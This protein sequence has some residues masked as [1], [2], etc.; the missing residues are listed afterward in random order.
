MKSIVYVDHVHADARWLVPFILPQN[1][2]ADDP[3]IGLNANMSNTIKDSLKA[4]IGSV[5]RVVDGLS[6]V[7]HG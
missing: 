1:N 6:Q 2:L 4:W 3:E 7:R 5:E